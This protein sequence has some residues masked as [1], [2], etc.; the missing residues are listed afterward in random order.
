MDFE[1]RFGN[2]SGGLDRL[3]IRKISDPELKLVE[4]QRGKL[5][6]TPI[7]AGL[8]KRDEYRENPDYNV[9]SI[10]TNY[11]EGLFYNLREDRPIIS[12][13]EPAP[14]DPSIT[15]GLAIRKAISYAINRDEIN[16][17]LFGGE[18]ILQ[19]HPISSILGKWCNPDIIRYNHNLDKA[20]EYMQ[21]AGYGE[22]ELIPS[23]LNGWEI[24]GIVVSSVIF[25]GAV[26]FV[27]YWLYWKGK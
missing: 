27:I 1:N 19:D 4:F 21:I 26:S 2:F 17:V 7:V 22:E 15:K 12:S 10:Y 3:K 16:Q 25:T 18:F 9:Q 14:G 8:D 13:Q 20:R 6:Y 23:G 24:A 11:I 5:D